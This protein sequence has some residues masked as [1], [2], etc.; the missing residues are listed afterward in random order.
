MYRH[1]QRTLGIWLER[2]R[3]GARSQA[4]R[5]R[6]ALAALDVVDRHRLAR[7][8]AWLCLAAQQRGGTDLATRLRRL[9]ASLYALVAEAMQRLPSIGGGLSS[10]RRLSA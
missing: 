3:A 9:D 5:A 8:L 6:L 4:F 7:W 1:A 10:E 2:T